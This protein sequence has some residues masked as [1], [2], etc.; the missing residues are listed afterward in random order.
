MCENETNMMEELDELSKENQMLKAEMA[1]LTQQHEK[2]GD[3]MQF[4][5]KNNEQEVG[6]RLQFEAKLNSLHALHRDLQS[7]YERAT[8]EIFQLEKTTAENKVTIETQKEEL[9]DLRTLKIEQET[10][11]SYFTEKLKHAQIDCAAKQSII[12]SQ[13]NKLL[14]QN[15]Q[16]LKK[17]S[18][19]KNM[20][21]KFNAYRL[22]LEASEAAITNL[23]GEKEHLELSL[24]ENKKLKERYFKKSEEVQ[25]KYQDIH[26]ELNE[27]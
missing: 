25:A 3:D 14:S 26:K 21:Q 10:Q 4:L 18:E 23:K 20:D 5:V 8:E 27:V 6:L 9:V 22:K 7:R 16:I 17:E 24:A 12:A 15:E 13:E 19:L 11:I 1:Q 2:L